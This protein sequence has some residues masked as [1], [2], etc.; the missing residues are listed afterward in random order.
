MRTL[1]R[2]RR[3]D[4]YISCSKKG[5]RFIREGGGGGGLFDRDLLKDLRYV[6]P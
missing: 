6:N 5:G 2:E 3:V 4:K 1:E